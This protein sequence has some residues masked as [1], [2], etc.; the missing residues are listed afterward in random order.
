MTKGGPTAYKERR[1]MQ[2][3]VALARQ[4]RWFGM[5]VVNFQLF[6]ALIPMLYVIWEESSP[7]PHLKPINKSH[8]RG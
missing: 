5:T 3:N 7:G 6:E 4:T 2:T 8:I 1:I